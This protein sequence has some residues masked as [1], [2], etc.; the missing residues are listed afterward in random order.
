VQFSLRGLFGVT[1]GLVE[2]VEVNLLGLSFG[3]DPWPPALKL[4]IAGRV[5]FAHGGA[6]LPEPVVSD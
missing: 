2:G 6:H 4:P 1:A 3:L 5:G